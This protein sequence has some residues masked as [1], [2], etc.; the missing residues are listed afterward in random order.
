MQLLSWKP[1]AATVLGLMTGWVGAMPLTEQLQVTQCLAKK[2]PDYPVLAQDQ[3]FKIIDV[4]SGE[5]TA[6]SRRADEAGCG[7]FVNVSH[8]LLA[9]NNQTAAALLRAPQPAFAAWASPLKTIAHRQ[10]VEAAFNQIS[11]DAIWKTLSHLTEYVNRSALQS[12]GV[13][14]AQWLKTSFETMATEAGR[15]DTETWFVSTGPYQQPSLVTV[16]G[17]DINAPAVVIGAHMDTLDGRMPG[18]GDDG[19]G[20]ANVMEIARVLL[21]ERVALKRPI[22]LIWYAAEERGLVGSQYVVQD[23]LQKKRPVHAVLQLDMA[24]YRHNPTDPTMWVYRDYTDK[25]LNK[26]VAQLIT[27]YINVP[28]KYSECGYGCSDHA[29]WTAQGISASFPCETS[30]ADHNP[31]IHTSA[32]TLSLISIDHMVNFTKLGLAFALELAL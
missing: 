19:T 32:D 10:H 6:V 13:D 1:I 18:A 20:S 23:F 15:K 22:Y 12:T 2:L 11:P 14:T 24:G 26:W 7:R 31:Y 25:S 21:H 27:S 29:S 16:I 30:F 5:L 9:V 3:A 8:R 4:P 17:K 28:V